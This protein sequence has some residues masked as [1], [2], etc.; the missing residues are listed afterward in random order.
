MISQSVK[1]VSLIFVCGT[2]LIACAPS[3]HKREPPIS[4]VEL[5]Q[6]ELFNQNRANNNSN[7]NNIAELPYT[8]IT[9]PQQVVQT[10]SLPTVATLTEDSTKDFDLST[11]GDFEFNFEQISLTQLIEIIADALKISTIVDPSIGDKVTIRT[12]PDKILHREDLWPLLQL[13][14]TDAG[15]SVEKKAGVYHFK[16]TGPEL[17]GTIGLPSG[18]SGDGE[19]AE[20]LQVTPLRFI[21]VESATAVLNPLIQQQGRIITLP[22]LN[23]LGIITTPQ[24]LERVNKLLALVDADPFLHRGM[25]LFRLNNSK[26]TEVQ[27]DLDKILQALTGQTGS[28]QSIALERINAILVISPP[29]AGFDEVSMWINILDEKGED[30][31]EQVFVYRVKNVEAKE[32]AST[33]TSVFKNEEEDI[34]NRDQTDNEENDALTNVLNPENVAELT[35]PSTPRPEGAVSA[36]LKVTIV[37]DEGTNSLLVRATPR[38]YRQLLETIAALDRVPK[39][40]MIHAAVAE[41]SLSDSTK[42]GI[43]WEAFFGSTRQVGDTQDRSSISSNLGIRGDTTASGLI[44]NHIAGGLTAILNLAASNNELRVLMRPSILVRNNQKARINVGS[45]EPYL[46][47]INTSTTNYTQTSRDVQYKD[48]G[49]ILEVTPRINDEGI[50]SLD[51]VQELSQLGS[52]PRTSEQL[53]S[54][55]QRKVETSVVVRDGSAIIIGGLIQTQNENKNSGIPGLRDVPVVGGAFST[56]TITHDRTELVLIIIPEIVNPELDSR[57]LMQ[58]FKQ[59]MR[60][61]DNLLNTEGVYIR[62]LYAPEENTTQATVRKMSQ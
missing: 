48:V 14:L 43:D 21:T 33:L 4:A 1:I 3:V 24:R 17:P 23:I 18:T 11:A 41:V 38:D 5:A 60:A 51:I 35:T 53:T 32:L 58:R 37:A 29:D 8:P 2:F 28:Y 6:Q 15:I 49:I 7:D 62:E 20:I 19:A 12:S 61:I 42:F 36:A 26:A 52:T 27:A 44:I 50:V 30:S 45:N 59:Q 16:K 46:S 55:D 57:P 22:N 31:S 25:R 39:E 10:G 13:L 47:S 54:F 56:D 9:P 34:P 40:V